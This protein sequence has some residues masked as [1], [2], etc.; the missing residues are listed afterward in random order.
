MLFIYAYV[1]SGILSE[2]EYD[3]LTE[4]FDYLVSNP[5]VHVDLF[6]NSSSLLPF[7]KLWAITK[8]H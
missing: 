8:N 2:L 5:D 4:W 3:V 1:V 6:G 7:L